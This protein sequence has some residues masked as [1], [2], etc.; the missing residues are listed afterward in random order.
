MTRIA[1]IS[2]VHA[3]VRALTDALLRADRL[4]CDAIVCAGDLVDYG[5]PTQRFRVFRA[6]QDPS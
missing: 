5:M 1:I 3:D 4:G 2:D 6:A